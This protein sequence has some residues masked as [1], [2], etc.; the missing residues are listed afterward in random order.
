MCVFDKRKIPNFLKFSKQHTYGSHSVRRFYQ[1]DTC[2]RILPAAG[3]RRWHHA[4]KVPRCRDPAI[5]RSSYRWTAAGKCIC[6]LTAR[7]SWQRNC[8]GRNCS[9]NRN[10]TCRWRSVSSRSSW[11]SFSRLTCNENLGILLCSLHPCCLDCSCPCLFSATS[12]IPGRCTD[13]PR[14]SAGMSRRF[15]RANWRTHC[16]RTLSRDSSRERPCRDPREDPRWSDWSSVCVCSREIHGWYRCCRRPC[17]E[18]S[19]SCILSLR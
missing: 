10:C 1:E 13:P 11:S 4:G 6:S 9:R 18:K 16:H 7:T 2:T 5:L 14:R 15:D 17:S 3:C 8:Y 19:Q 12:Y